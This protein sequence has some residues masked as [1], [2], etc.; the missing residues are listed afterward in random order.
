MINL[1]AV[2][3]TELKE[4]VTWMLSFQRSN[5]SSGM[6]KNKVKQDGPSGGDQ[7]RAAWASSPL[8]LK[9]LSPAETEGYFNSWRIPLFKEMA[10]LKVCKMKFSLWQLTAGCPCL[11]KRQV[12]GSPRKLLPSPEKQVILRL[13]WPLEGQ[14]PCNPQTRPQPHLWAANDLIK[15]CLDDM[16]F[17]QVSSSHLLSQCLF[18]TVQTYTEGLCCPFKGLPKALHSALPQP[19]IVA[20]S[21]SLN[22]P[23]PGDCRDKGRYRCIL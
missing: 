17:L 6:Q 18:S 5:E 15:L 19:A 7:I 2:C 10:V 1:W 23:I 12:E 16:H 21:C 22:N 3:V 4:E 14:W 11:W 9:I 20:T 13:H 8:S